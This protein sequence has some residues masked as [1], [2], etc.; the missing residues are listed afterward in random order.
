MEL[1]QIKRSSFHMKNKPF[2]HDAN[3]LYLF[4][5]VSERDKYRLL[6]CSSRSSSAARS[7]RSPL[8]LCC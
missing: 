4:A 2:V 6:L 7:K 5:V 3:E 1:G 8:V